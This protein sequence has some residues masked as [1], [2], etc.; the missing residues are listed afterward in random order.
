MLYKKSRIRDRLPATD[1]S[2]NTPISSC[3]LTYPYLTARYL[4]LPLNP[5]CNIFMT[6]TYPASTSQALNKTAYPTYPSKPKP[7]TRLGYFYDTAILSWGYGWG[8]YWGWGWFEAEVEMRLSRGLVEI[9]LSWGWDK[10]TMHR[11]RNWAL[12][13]VGLW[14]KIRFRSTHVAEQHMFSL[15]PSILAFNFI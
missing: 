2:L 13:G 6:Y 14:S 7:E 12:L 15:S 3:S 1:T 10:F 9:E 4:P 5:L 8:W 11:G